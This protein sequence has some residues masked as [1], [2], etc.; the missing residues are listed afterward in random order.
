MTE[1]ITTD[2]LALAEL[3]AAVVV[4]QPGVAALHGGIFGDVATYLPGRKLTGVRVGEPG[5]PVE[6]GVVLR[7]GRPIPAVVDALRRA[8]AEVC[9]DRRVDIVVA[10]VVADHVVAGDAAVVIDDGPA[11]DPAVGTGQRR[12][13]R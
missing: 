5:E 11:V 10:D 2:P 8:V 13:V 4:S 7:L 1:P 6:I 12:R 9:G 3:V